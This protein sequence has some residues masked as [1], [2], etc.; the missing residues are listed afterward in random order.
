MEFVVKLRR[1]INLG[2]YLLTSG[3][4][5]QNYEDG[6]RWNNFASFSWE[7]KAVYWPYESNINYRTLQTQCAGEIPSQQGWSRQWWL[8]VTIKF[9]VYT[10]RNMFRI[11][12][13]GGYDD[14]LSMRRQRIRI[15][16][17]TKISWG[18]S[19][20]R[21]QWKSMDNISIHIRD[22]VNMGDG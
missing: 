6:I 21:L 3:I 14:G 13:T 18:M 9:L 1:S 15:T 19:I 17:G 22:L 20:E 4:L 16:F 12:S 8:Y 10:W 5:F 2:N 7:W 11:T